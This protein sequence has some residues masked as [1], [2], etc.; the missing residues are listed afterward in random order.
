MSGPLLLCVILFLAGP[1][2]A[3]NPLIEN[4]RVAVLDVTGSTTAQ[5]LDAVIVTLSGRATFLPKGTPPKI[6]GRSIVIDLKD[7]PVAPIAKYDPL[8]AGVSAAR[9]EEDTGECTSD[10]VELHLDA[11]RGH[12]DALPR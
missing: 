5:P 6:T 11:G 3:L 12:P 1:Q 4:D 7:H 2:T 8:P 10:R 9:I